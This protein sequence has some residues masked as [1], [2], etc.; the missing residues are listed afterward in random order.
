MT[1]W[2]IIPVKGTGEGKTRLAGALSTAERDALV[3]AM[4]AHVVEA[5]RQAR[6]IDR[7]CL[8]GPS[9]RGLDESLPLIP[10]S[11]NGLNAALEA[12]LAEVARSGP[13]RLVVVPVDLPCVTPGDLDL[14]ANVPQGTVG[15]APDRHG[16]GTNGLSLP[17]PGASNFAFHFGPGSYGRHLAEAERLG[18]PVETV[19][20]EGLAKDIDEPADLT[21]ATQVFSPGGNS[22]P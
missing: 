12:A 7:L 21:D 15:I 10:D 20:S 8:V 4:L 5:G 2:A 13:D 6:S 11:G 1:C 16:T 17:L 22:Q 14:L 19:R 9:R 3:D 18:L